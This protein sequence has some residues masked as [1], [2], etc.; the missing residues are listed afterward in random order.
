MYDE[1]IL[2]RVIVRVHSC[3]SYAL[4]GKKLQMFRNFR[5]FRKCIYKHKKRRSREKYIHSDR[6]KK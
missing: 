1:T 2:R 3:Y 4:T 5:K 6:R